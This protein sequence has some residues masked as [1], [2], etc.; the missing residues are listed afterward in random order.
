MPVEVGR[1]RVLLAWEGGAGRGHAVT[2]KVIAQALHDEVFCDAALCR[3]DHASELQPHCDSVFQGARLSVNRSRREA[4]GNPHVATWGDFLGDLNFWNPQFLIAQIKWWLDTI[5]A[6][7]SQLVVAD[8]APCAQ[9]AAQIAG[10]PSV[11]VGTGYSVPPSGLDR[12]PFLLP[13]YTKLVFAEDELLR[14][15]NMALVHFGARPL[16]RLSDI[17]SESTAMPRT[18]SGLDPYKGARR[19]PLL[20]PLNERL[21]R[22]DGSGDEVFFYFS[23]SETE[24]H[25][26]VDA[27]IGLDLPMRAFIPGAS[28]ETK[29]LFIEAGVTVETRPSSFEEINRRSRLLLHSGQHGTL[30]MGLGMGIGQVAFPQHLEHHFHARRAADLA[31]VRVVN[32]GANNA[33]EIS[34]AIMEAYEIGGGDAAAVERLRSDLF[35]DVGALVRGRILPLIH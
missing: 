30:C 29:E 25:A 4:A 3:L 23:A 31:P 7:K 2:L 33:D 9:L 26:L 14:A 35:G 8:F 20:P 18:I 17:Y 12:F 27:L 10:I 24:N 19:A 5:K 28:A 13:E 11:A 6:R 32:S 1:P 16:A 15:V 21:P 22:P 34:A